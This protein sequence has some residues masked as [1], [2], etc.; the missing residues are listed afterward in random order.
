MSN[1]EDTAVY[2]I[3]AFIVLAIA[4]MIS[5]AIGHDSGY[6]DGFLRGATIACGKRGS[7]FDSDGKFQGCAEGGR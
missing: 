1:F 4:T 6:R 2:A 7:V 5:F 3:V